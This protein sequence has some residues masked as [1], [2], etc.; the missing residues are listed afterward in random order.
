MKYYTTP[1]TVFDAMTKKI[2]ISTALSGFVKAFLEK[3]VLILQSMGYEVHF[4]S[5][6]TIDGEKY[7]PYFEKMGIVFHQV[8][9]SSNN[10]FSRNT[11]NC[12]RQF[13][14]I[15]KQEGF[16]A[17]HI[18]TP[19]PGV[20]GRIAAN[21]YRRKGTKV[22][23]TTHGFYFHKKSDI[24]TKLIYKTVEIIMS[25][26][27]DAVITINKE[28]YEAAKR[29]L[30]KNVFLIPGMGVDIMRFRNVEVNRTEYR[31]SLGIS[32]DAFMILTVGEL[33]RRKNHK[34]IVEALSKCAIPNAVFVIC[35]EALTGDDTRN[36]LIEMASE[37]GVDLKLLGN[38]K[39]IPEICK[40]AD[41]GVL[42]SL[43]EGLGLAGIEMLASGMPIVASGLH[44]IVDYVRD[45][46][47]GFL[48]DPLN[49]SDF[50]D[51]IKKLYDPE[52]R[53]NMAINC[54]ASVEQFDIKKSKESIEKIYRKMLG[55]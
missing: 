49:S 10:P 54:S 26:M 36:M 23:Y 46:Y 47:N 55:D 19:I 11:L 25:A 42:P 31:E 48:A 28:D 37:R 9:F 51:K 53:N 34:V 7:I 29:M 40:C 43:R 21:K 32:E 5:N 50:A 35:G 8:D 3:D 13:S 38:R 44:G 27:T 45:G 4:A 6:N 39:D 12:L 33:S 15:L 18:H 41:I 2:L 22:L 16:D 30:C 14:D 1:Q 24:K 52:I 17:V 20:I